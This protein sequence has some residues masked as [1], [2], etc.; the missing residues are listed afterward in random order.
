MNN[1]IIIIIL[2][3][4]M[5]T[6]VYFPAVYKQHLIFEEKRIGLDIPF[7]GEERAA[8][9]ANLEVNIA[10]IGSL[11]YL[12]TLPFARYDIS[13]AA[14]DSV[15]IETIAILH[16]TPYHMRSD[17]GLGVVFRD[18][19]EEY[20]DF[21]GLAA[22]RYQQINYFQIWNEPDIPPAYAVANYYGGWGNAPEEYAAFVSRCGSS[23]KWYRPDASIAISLAGNL[24]WLDHF[25]VAG[26][27][28]YVDYVYLHYY[29]WWGDNQ[30][31]AL[32]ELRERLETVEHMT[33]ASVWLTETNLLSQETMPEYEQAKA[34]WIMSLEKA[35]D[36]TNVIMV[37]SF[38][39]GWNNADINGL[40]A[41]SA[42]RYLASKYNVNKLP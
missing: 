40:P 28:N 17:N 20:A 41:E 3:V 2:A 35:L 30:Y 37:Y 19:W 18:Y 31:A 8:E 7:P 42:V 10:T 36:K 11:I 32:A 12:P 33:N 27:M 1:I 16:G 25:I 4:T 39:S 13:V 29:V 38:Q 23:I 6:Q 5:T 14:L 9:A 15:G 21:C 22:S 26:G 34:E 24:D